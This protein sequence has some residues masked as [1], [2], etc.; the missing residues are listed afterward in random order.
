MISE[1][2]KEDVLKQ[3][4]SIHSWNAPLSTVGYLFTIK[5]NLVNTGMYCSA[6]DRANGEI[7]GDKWDG[8]LDFETKQ[9][10]DLRK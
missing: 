1:K 7:S 2:V 8:Y 4:G 3:V 10:K 9:Y 6:T 5:N